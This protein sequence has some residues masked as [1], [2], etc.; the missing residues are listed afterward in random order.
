MTGICR[1]QRLMDAGAE[2]DKVESAAETALQQDFG[3]TAE[4]ARTMYA[5]SNKETYSREIYKVL[6]KAG[7]SEVTE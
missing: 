6:E 4:D 1:M 3:L 2:F 7:L 5:L